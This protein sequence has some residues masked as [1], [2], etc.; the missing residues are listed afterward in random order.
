M[1]VDIWFREDVVRILASTQE[2]MVN[3][4]SAVAPIESGVTDA[5]QQGFDAALLSVGIAFGVCPPQAV[6]KVE[7]VRPSGTVQT[8]D[9][10]TSINGSFGQQR[11]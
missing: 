5:Y 1:A 2:T 6:R 10:P 9:V 4:V 11:R 7:R 8:V 3:S